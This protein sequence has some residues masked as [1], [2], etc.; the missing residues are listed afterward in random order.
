M[1]YDISVIIP[2]YNASDYIEHTLRS[3]EQQCFE[4]KIE[5]ICVDDCSTDD[6]VL[7]V[8]EFSEESTLPLTV[9]RQPT[10]RRQG[11]ARNR[12]LH[13]ARG[14][15]TFFLDSDDF[16]DEHTFEEMFRKAEEGACDFVLCDWTFY[17]EE[18]GEHYVNNDLFMVETDLLGKECERL[19]QSRY[20]FSVNKLYRTDFLRTNEIYFGEGYI[21]EDFEFYVHVVGQ[22]DHIGIVN[23]PFY[24]VRVNEQSVTKTNY[25][26]DVHMRDFL[27]A[28]EKSLALFQPRHEESYY[29]VYKYFF[30]RCLLYADRRVPSRYKKEMIERTTRLL[31]AKETNFFVPRKI[32][33]ENQLYFRRGLIQREQTR[34]IM[35]VDWLS[36][37]RRLRKVYRIYAAGRRF[38]SVRMWVH[39]LK[40][41]KLNKRRRRRAM[42][43]VK[44]HSRE[45][46][47]QKKVLFLGFDYRY[48]G[49]S[50]YLFDYMTTH[51]PD[52]DVQMVTSDERVPLA[53]RI[54]PR[55]AAF[56]QALGEASVL[57][58]ESWTPLAFFKKEGALWIQLW[59]GTPYKK[60]FFDSH[61]KYIAKH[62]RNHKRHKKQDIEKWDVLIA[63]STGAVDLFA[64]AF[65]K[66][67]DKI[68]PVGYPRVQWL[69][70][71]DENEALKREL[72]E[73][74]AIRPEQT[75][76]LY[77]PTWRDYNFKN[78]NP[79]LNYVLDI[80]AFME[81]LGEDY[82]LITKMH[83]MEKGT[84]AQPNIV[85]A[86]TEME[87]QE[88]LLISDTVITDYSS[89]LFDVLPIGKK[90]ALYT[91]DRNRFDEARGT[92]A[93][94]DQ[95]LA[96]FTF[97]SVAALENFIQAPM[98]EAE[99]ASYNKLL[100]KYGNTFEGNSNRAIV[101]IIQ[102]HLEK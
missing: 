101:E 18:T 35:L 1:T 16:L 99:Q 52:I 98:N 89:I 22:A 58:T 27:T 83:P 38:F 15:Y 55:S 3:I 60:M 36:R 64:S 24:K 90:I 86:P 32:V 25:T 6:T 97:D 91:N 92:Y 93:A 71:Q 87:T 73:K 80:G 96:P 76:L 23:N 11:A 84:V 65:S 33:L 29:M 20:Y 19:Y 48:M 81:A 26:T 78:P 46:A 47:L 37:K 49:N 88:L 50:K 62:N 66:E 12:G 4:G 56:W 45:V 8:E 44:R 14:T 100:E 82:L 10:N 21:Y 57:I 28:V 79:D 102:D 69:I 51:H 77:A 17:Y 7:L 94:L 67:R 42:A 70:E 2:M 75:V 54:K 41:S 63:D 43:K 68:A 95:L 5:I 85:S 74:L 30:E 40:Q 31:N 53:N 39:R 59:H 61:E 9:L 72:T 13:E 34:A